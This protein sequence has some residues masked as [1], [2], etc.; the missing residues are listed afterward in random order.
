ML[1]V[2]FVLSRLD[3][4]DGVASHVELLASQL[5]EHGIELSMFTGLTTG[6][7][8]A[9]GR[10]D[11][12]RTMFPD[13]GKLGDEPLGWRLGV[14]R[15]LSSGLRRGRFDLVHVHGLGL[16]P[17]V[18]AAMAGTG[19]PVVATYHPSA[20]GAE[21]GDFRLGIGRRRLMAYRMFLRAFGPRSLVAL[22]SETYA[23]FTQDCGMPPGRVDKIICGID[24]DHFRRPTAAERAG[25][26]A[27]LGLDDETLVCVLPGRLNLNKGHDVAIAAL[28][29]VRKARPSLRIACLFPGLGA[30]EAE[31][32]ALVAAS[33]HPDMYAFLG[34]VPEM[35]DVYW[36]SDLALL[37]SRTEGFAIVI[38]EAMACGN[39]AIRTPSGGS[40]D[41]IIAGRTGYTVAFNDPDALAGRI[42][43]CAD[44][45]VLDALRDNAAELA[46]E[47]FSGLRLGNETVALYGRLQP[48]RLPRH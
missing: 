13:W 15:G 21:A 37:P 10:Y 14:L 43:D 23:L 45:T 19:V 36:A 26:R 31:I 41:Q 20:H 47:R 12:L 11:A 7:T 4:N 28:D 24:T 3:C 48:G 44:R 46:K 30:Q 40:S 6:E 17:L 27:A 9:K 16:L 34:F 33:P 39:A 8:V 29:R 35:R 25:A 1:K 38:A 22:S 5:V 42:L 32:R 18:R 2:A